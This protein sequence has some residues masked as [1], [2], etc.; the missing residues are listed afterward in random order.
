MN[1]NEVFMPNMRSRSLLCI[2]SAES[3]PVLGSDSNQQSNCLGGKCG[4]LFSSFTSRF[5]TKYDAFCG[6][7]TFVCALKKSP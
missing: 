3:K 7:F 4:I 6:I 1:Q 2:I 5:I